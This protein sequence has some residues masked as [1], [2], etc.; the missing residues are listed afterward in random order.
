M[1]FR[2]SVDEIAETL[3]NAR[4]RGRG[5]TLLIGAGCSVK[6]GIPTANGFVEVIK[7]RYRHAYNRAQEKTYPKCMA[8][9]HLS[10]RRDLIA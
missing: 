5:C 2:R 9:L 1:N 3:E 6:A 10:E 7:K 4:T 8:E